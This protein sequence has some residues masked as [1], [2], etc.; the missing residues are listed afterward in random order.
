MKNFMKIGLG[1]GLFLAVTTVNAST[2]DGDGSFKVNSGKEK[3]IRFYLKDSKD[4]KISICAE[5]Q[6]VLYK[7]KVTKNT[8]VSKVYD[9][10]EL[11]DGKYSLLVESGTKVTT[12][13]LLVAN[14][15][16][17][18]SQ[19]STTAVLKPV[20]T[21]ENGLVTLKLA[22]LDKSALELKVLD[23]NNEELYSG[24]YTDRSKLSQKFNIIQSNAK[25]LTFV[26]NYNNQKY[27]ETI[28]NQ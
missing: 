20:I 23:E 3:S 10:K 24:V 18:I 22:N 7:E 15:T 12:Y 28:D 2:I 26:V 8:P 19:P 14:N 9:L 11:P 5:N 16:T 6:E 21:K 27:V 17:L 4:V 13:D 1:F 25:S